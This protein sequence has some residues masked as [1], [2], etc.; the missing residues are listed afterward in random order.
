MR[1]PDL[2]WML[3]SWLVLVNCGEPA[4]RTEAVTAVGSAA[5]AAR[6]VETEDSAARAD[7]AEV[8]APEAIAGEDVVP[9][10][11]VPAT[12]EAA[13]RQMAAWLVERDAPVP[14]L[15]DDRS[16]IVVAMDCGA[17]DGS[18]P[19]KTAQAVGLDGLIA[20]D[21]DLRKG[22]VLGLWDF[23]DQVDCKDGCCR[24]LIDPEVGLQEHMLGLKKVCVRT[25]EDGKPLGYTRIEGVGG[26]LKLGAR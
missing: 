26:R 3:S 2:A 6:S 22:V 21:R 7:A 19:G 4:A 25:D 8:A 20:V 23:G 11:P 12:A 24:F 13:A 18:E 5:G 10:A 15:L 17:C 1:S 14:A 9:R 16:Q